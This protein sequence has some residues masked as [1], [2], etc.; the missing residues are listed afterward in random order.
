MVGF[1]G[2][3]GGGGFAG[4]DAMEV[5]PLVV[6]GLLWLSADGRRDRFPGGEGERE[7]ISFGCAMTQV[8]SDGCDIETT[9]YSDRD[10]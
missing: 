1:G 9:K 5:T 4:A 8:V 10:Y 6:N 2:R 3:D 7:F